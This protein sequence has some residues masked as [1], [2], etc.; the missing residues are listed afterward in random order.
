[1]GRKL[2]TVNLRIP[3]EMYS[4]L[5]KCGGKFNPAIVEMWERHNMEKVVREADLAGVFTA[6]EWKAMLMAFDGRYGEIGS[7]MR[8][9][10]L[11]LIESM[12]ERAEADGGEPCVS[13]VSLSVLSGK[14][15]GL[16]F[17][18]CATLADRIREFGLSGDICDACEVERWAMMRVRCVMPR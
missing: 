4:D 18:Q 9:E 2:R 14:I 11:F 16:T 5:T 10:P 15:R 13:G 6:D 17:I 3:E 7:Q 8:Y 12:Y 1:M